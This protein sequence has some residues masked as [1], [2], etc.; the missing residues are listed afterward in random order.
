MSYIFWK[1]YVNTNKEMSLRDKLD[2]LSA[3]F[4]PYGD[5]LD[6][7]YWNNDVELS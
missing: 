7:Y 2:N 1:E 3:P 4:P 5:F 6:I